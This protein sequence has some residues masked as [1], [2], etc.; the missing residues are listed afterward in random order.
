MTIKKIDEFMVG[1]GDLMKALGI[2][3]AVFNILIEAGMP[4]R[5]YNKR[6]YF[7]LE[8]VN[9]WLKQWTAVCVGQVPEE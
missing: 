7:H 6:W 8:N 1:Q 2:G 4:G 5:F 9:A 3:D